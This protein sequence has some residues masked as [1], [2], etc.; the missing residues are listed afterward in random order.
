MP[1]ALTKALE[2]R[3][4][5]TGS[6]KNLTLFYA[7]AQGNRD[8]SGADHFAHEGM[9]KRVIGGHWNMGS[10]RLDSWSLITKLKDTICR[11]ALWHSS[12]VPSPVT[13][14]A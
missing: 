8:G 10:R 12:T 14:P 9:T 2:K 3:F 1:E 5:E 13:N 7:A 11:R 6:P 4:L